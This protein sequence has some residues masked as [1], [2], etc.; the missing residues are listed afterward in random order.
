MTLLSSSSRRHAFVVLL[1]SLSAAL[2]LL[3]GCHSDAASARLSD[4]LYALRLDHAPTSE[5]W[6]RALPRL[7]IVRGGN[8][9]KV[10]PLPDV[11]SDT[12][13]VTTASCH[14]GSTPPA[15]LEVDLRAFY[16][17]T[18]LYLRIS[19][20]DPTRDEAMRQWRFNGTEWLASAS[21]EDGF[22]ILW[23]T[24]A[25]FPRFTC[26]YAC[27]IDNFGV[28][29][30][31]FH[32]INRMKLAKDDG[33][34]LDL[35][36][37]KSG[38]TARFGFADDR[39]LDFKGMEGDTPGELFVPN[40]RARLDGKEAEI[41]SP[42]DAPIFD[43]DNETIGKEFRPA[44]SVAPGYITERPIGSRAD[45]AAITEYR[46]HR[47]TVILHRSLRTADPRDVI[48]SPTTGAGIFFGLSVMD[49]TLKEHY[50]SVLPERLVLLPDA[51]AK[52]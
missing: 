19:W 33:L 51:G 31:N 23:D 17:S 16:T 5:D 28:S 18:D 46:D 8:V 47:W 6:A 4:R 29:G 10:N 52:P 40:S 42:G 34:R 45:V 20:P 39:T 1:L 35:W 25:S 37:W 9:H 48:F 44:G 14:H 43:A 26:S 49:D 13:H 32:A 22:G 11:D 21:H 30:A 3:T 7:L 2:P 38:R 27:H 41:F 12:V 36:N 15:P 24:G 50:A